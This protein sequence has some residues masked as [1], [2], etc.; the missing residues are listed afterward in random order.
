MVKPCSL[1]PRRLE[2]GQSCH[3]T[4]RNQST[5]KGKSTLQTFSWRTFWIIMLQLFLVVWMER[6]MELRFARWIPNLEKSD[7]S[8]EVSSSSCIQSKIKDP[9]IPSQKFRIAFGFWKYG[10]IEMSVQVVRTKL[11]M[12]VYESECVSTKGIWL[13]KYVVG[14]RSE[15]HRKNVIFCHE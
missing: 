4:K 12:S 10:R 11:P 14:G 1:S 6:K 2:R 8:V 7:I 13:S 3:Y 5:T 9:I 15:L